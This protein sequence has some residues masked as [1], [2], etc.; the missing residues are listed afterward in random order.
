MRKH[1]S[2]RKA[3]LLNMLTEN[4]QLSVNDMAAILGVSS[5]TIRSDLN[6]LEK[7]GQ[8]IRTHGGAMPTLHPAISCRGKQA[9]DAKNRMA[10]TAAEMVQDGDS[11]LVG[12]GTSA[13]LVVKYLPG[14]RD[15]HVVT[16][17]TLLLPFARINPSLCV[18]LVG[19]EFCAAEEGM[20]GPLAMRA[21]EQFHVTKAFVGVDGVSIRQGFTAN[22]LE[23][24]E[25]VRKM[26]EQADEVI[27]LADHSKFGTP[28][29]ARILPLQGADTIITDQIPSAE[30]VEAFE[31]GKVKIIT[32]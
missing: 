21:M 6:A 22:M 29:F 3:R 31:L 8:V 32:P 4:N 17:S 16:N 25:L 11:I 7:E 9:Q 20:V 23:S 24:A 30:F 27:I 12:T 15:V 2:Q 28:G 14:R 19:G 5:V 18:T 10:K 1:L 13:S 26:V